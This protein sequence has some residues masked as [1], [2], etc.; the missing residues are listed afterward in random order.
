MKKPTCLVVEDEKPAQRILE[1]YIRRTG[2]FELL[3]IFDNVV[4]AMAFLEHNTP[5]LLILDIRMPGISGI[6]FARSYQAKSNI[7]FTTAFSD[8]AVEGFDLGVVDYLLKPFSFERFLTAVQRFSDKRRQQQTNQ[9]H[10]YLEQPQQTANLVVK[11]TKGLE[12]ISINEIEYL[13]S[14]GNYLK[15]VCGS[16]VFVCRST[17]P[18]MLS[19]LQEHSFLRVHRSFAV[20]LQKI[21]SIASGKIAVGRIHL[22]VGAAYHETLVRMWGKTGYPN[23]G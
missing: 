20:A 9:A 16:K 6:E 3:G 10:L 11:T 19:R 21:D 15:I 14:Y 1:N 2:M 17:L 7:M 23:E 22:P 13:Q 4:D 12:K 8:Y 5:D 18:A